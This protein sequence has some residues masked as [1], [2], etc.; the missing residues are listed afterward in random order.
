M[1][2]EENITEREAAEA[3]VLRIAAGGE[4]PRTL[5]QAAAMAD[6]TEKEGGIPARLAYAGVPL[7][8]IPDDGQRAEVAAAREADVN[9]AFSDLKATEDRRDVIRGIAAGLGQLGELGRK[10]S[11]D[12]MTD[13]LRESSFAD[14][15]PGH[16]SQAR[17]LAQTMTPWSADEEAELAGQVV[18]VLPDAPADPAAITEPQL[19]FVLSVRWRR[20]EGESGWERVDYSAGSARQVLGVILDQLPEDL[21]TRDQSPMPAGAGISE[22]IVLDWY[23]MPQGIADPVI[24]RVPEPEWEPDKQTLLTVLAGLV[25]I[26]EATALTPR[27]AAEEKGYLTAIEDVTLSFTETFAAFLPPAPL[28]PQDG[29]V[30][31]SQ[32]WTCDDCG[33]PWP[34]PGEPPS[35]SECDNCGGVLVNAEGDPA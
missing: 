3:A 33:W 7:S 19:S 35:G 9:E 31:E 15:A 17:G 27:P 14:P 18:Q 5:D 2:G 23:A 6:L 26:R 25:M 30:S 22:D 1:P 21:V 13:I 28:N 12:D 34:L 24:L 32:D 11:K 4:E 16:D 10:L 29:L 8:E 20:P